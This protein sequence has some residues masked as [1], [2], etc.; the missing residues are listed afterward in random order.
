MRAPLRKSLIHRNLWLERINSDGA[1]RWRLRTLL[2]C[3]QFQL[4]FDDL[5]LEE[6]DKGLEASIK[7]GLAKTNLPVKINWTGSEFYPIDGLRFIKS[8]YVRDSSKVAFGDKARVSLYRLLRGRQSF[9]VTVSC[10]VDI[11]DEVQEDLISLIS[12]IK[13]KK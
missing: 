5:M 1:W 12:S 11:C 9:T 10:R 3:W 4:L 7:Q 13:I 2:A 8:E 6:F